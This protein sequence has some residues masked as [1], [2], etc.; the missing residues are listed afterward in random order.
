M[1]LLEIRDQLDEVDQEITR[2]Y[3]KRMDLCAEVA[4]VKIESGKAVFDPKR[5]A[6]KL[7][8]VASYL[9]WILIRKRSGSCT[10]R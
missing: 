6:E 7:D 2:L 8:A 4:R 9:D 3:K 5:E 1:T 10:S